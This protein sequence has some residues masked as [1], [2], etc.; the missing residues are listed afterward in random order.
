MTLPSSSQ[1]SVYSIVHNLAIEKQAIQPMIIDISEE[2]ESVVSIIIIIS[3]PSAP[4]AK[5]F[6]KSVNREL[7]IHNYHTSIHGNKDD[8]WYLL[9]T[10]DIF[11]NIMSQ[12]SR[13]RYKLEE[14]WRRGTVI[15]LPN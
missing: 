4:Q 5:S 6:S 9:D 2:Y 3:F 1:E 14:I 7:A 13:D 12:E 8:N 15:E 10:G 11:I